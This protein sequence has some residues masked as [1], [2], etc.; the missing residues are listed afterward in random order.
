MLRHH[1]GQQSESSRARWRD[2]QVV[3]GSGDRSDAY[4][5]TISEGRVTDHR[6]NLTLYNIA[7]TGRGPVE[8]DAFAGHRPRLAQPV[9]TPQRLR[10]ERSRSRG[11]SNRARR[12]PRNRSGVRLCH[13]T[14]AIGVLIAHPES[15]EV[16]MSTNL[17]G[18]GR[19]RLR[20]SRCLPTGERGVL[21]EDIQVTPAY[22]PPSET[23][24]PSTRLARI[25]EGT[26]TRV[27]VSVRARMFAI[28]RR[29]AIH[30]KFWR[31]SFS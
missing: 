7:A 16:Q 2:P 8:Y 9:N 6:I 3:V 19:G 11:V 13:V 30:C 27:L 31:R 17:C 23:E 1:Q 14:A 10:E 12:N 26:A 20:G 21:L 29:A 15:D 4:A 5:R 24:L 25:R 22:Y 28:A 18:L